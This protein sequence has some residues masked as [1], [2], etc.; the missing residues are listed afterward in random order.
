MTNLRRLLKEKGFTG[1][2]FAEKCGVGT[3]I[4]YK[5]MCG[6]RPISPKLAARFAKVLKVDPSEILEDD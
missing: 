6:N 5:Y 3:S 2:T 1:K 4:I